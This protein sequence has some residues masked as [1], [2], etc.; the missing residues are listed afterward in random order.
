MTTLRAIDKKMLV[1][2]G[3]GDQEY[4]VG[5]LDINST[6]NENAVN[7]KTL[8]KCS[9]HTIDKEKCYIVHTVEDRIQNGT[10][11][12]PQMIVLSLLKLT[13]QLG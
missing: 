11:V 9:I 4:T 3:T 8:E 2:L 7:V 13:W 12:W 6:A 10:K 1:I 5:N